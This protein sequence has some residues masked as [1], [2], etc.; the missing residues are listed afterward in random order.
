MS[1]PIDPPS[2]DERLDDRLAIATLRELT[3]NVPGVVYRCLLD[4]R[5]TMLFVSD[6][7]E[8]LTGHPASSFV[9]NTDRAFADV[10]EPEDATRVADEVRESI[11][12]RRAWSV[13]YRVV[14]PDGEQRWVE[15]HGRAVHDEDG[16]VLFLDGAILDV[17]ARVEAEQELDRARIELEAKNVELQRTLD[18]LR[19]AQTRENA[20]FEAMNE[21]LPGAVLGG[22]YRIEA[23]IGAGG[24]GVVYR[25]NQ[26][27]LDREVA[28]KIL[29]PMGRGKSN[30]RLRRRFEQEARATCAVSHPNAVVVHD[31][32]VTPAGL[33]YLVMEL[34]HGHG[35]TEELDRHGR[36]PYRRAIEIAATVADVLA[37]AH[38]VGIV[39]RDVKPDNV[40]I[41]KIGDAETVKVLD[42]GLAKLLDTTD[43]NVSITERGL[44]V[45]TPDYMSPE[46]LSQA[47]QIGGAADV[48]SL[49]VMLFEMLTGRLPYDLPGTS[50]AHIV[51]AHLFQAPRRPSELVPSLAPEL[52]ALV[53]ECLAKDPSERPDAAS[54]ARRLGE[55]R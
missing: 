53:L 42:F 4:A 39:H 21:L 23:Q 34:L 2:F 47:E 11:D 30:E 31:A 51:A 12:A 17:T 22:R 28:V 37:A 16:R 29:R 52:D 27:G 3:A 10:I 9:G 49:G 36:L 6:G 35:V 24:M 8:E 32:G 40:F 44:L 20:L 43:T 19:G 48:Y 13:R 50:S 26:L 54:V 18:E 5:W 33:V 45:G 41:A 46:R 1:Q 14:R 25:A 15:E 38:A 7:V 55:L